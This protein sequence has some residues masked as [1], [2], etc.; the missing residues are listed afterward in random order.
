MIANQQK[1]KE[2]CGAKGL[3]FGEECVE[4][5][6]LDSRET[7]RFMALTFGQ[8]RRPRCNKL[9]LTTSL[10]DSKLVINRFVIE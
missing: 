4:K 7:V 10:G 1:L 9:K 3:A 5:S 8:Q 6:K 2:F